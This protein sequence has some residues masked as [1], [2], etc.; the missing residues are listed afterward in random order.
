MNIFDISAVSANPLVLML[1]DDNCSIRIQ[2]FDFTPL[3]NGLPSYNFKPVVVSRKKITNFQLKKKIK[4]T[5][6]R[7]IISAINNLIKEHSNAD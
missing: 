3:D 2:D 5:V 7:F 4:R 6:G 1:T